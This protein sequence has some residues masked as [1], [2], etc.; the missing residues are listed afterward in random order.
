MKAYLPAAGYGT[1]LRPLTDRIPKCLVPIQGKP[2]LGWWLDLL[3]RHGVTDALVNTH[4]LAEQVRAYI[5]EYN[6]RGTGTTAHE[7][8]EPELL[9]SGGTI[10][11]NEDFIGAD[12]DFLICYADT[13]SNIDLTALMA[14]HRAA[15]GLL[16]MALFRS[17]H[18][19]ACGVAELDEEDRIIEFIEKPE[20]P[21]GNHASAGVYAAKR[22]IFKHF[23]DRPFID[24]AKDVQQNLVGRMYGYDIIGCHID[25]GTPEN[26]QKAQL[27]VLGE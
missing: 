1:R 6:D 18:P 5:G 12:E 15:G 9:G 13:L 25:I 11:A 22:E 8:Y 14:K 23:P 27:Y 16:T 24:F 21:K 7:F 26:Y 17:D 20:H 19:E 3:S 4:Y 2:L 10:H